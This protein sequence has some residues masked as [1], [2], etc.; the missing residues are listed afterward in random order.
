MASV[1][2]FTD[3]SLDQMNFSEVYKNKLGGKAIYLTGKNNQKLQLQL[4]AMRAPFG[5]SPYED[6]ATKRVTYTI[7]L[8]LDDDS[9][10]EFFT[11]LDQKILEYMVNNSE[12]VLGKKMSLEVLT[13]LYTPLTKYGKDPAYAPQLKLKVQ[14]G[15]NG[16]FV[17]KAYDMKRNPIPLTDIEKQDMIHTIVDI[18]QIWVVDKKFGVSVRLEQVMKVP[19]N[20]L[21]E[22]AF[23][24]SDGEDEI[25]VPAFVESE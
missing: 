24:V 22:C 3:F 11:A 14:Q 2:K 13:E 15:R 25:D 12:E 9:L 18:N 19:S 21:S 23:A 10:K 7:P 16:E 4:P 5:L 6:K 17:P 8:S 20:K 1:T